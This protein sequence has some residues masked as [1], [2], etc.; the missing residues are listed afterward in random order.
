MSDNLII[1]NISSLEQKD[2]ATKQEVVIIDEN[3]ELNKEEN[4][5]IVVQDMDP[6]KYNELLRE[7]ESLKSMIIDLH[8]IN[9]LETIS[10][11]S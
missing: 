10:I 8:T 11:V 3:D 6:K 1:D 2:E 9:Y 5:W 7:I 4:K